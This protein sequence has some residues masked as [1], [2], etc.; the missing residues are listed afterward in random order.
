M[1]INQREPLI[2]FPKEVKLDRRVRGS[3]KEKHR[4]QFKEWLLENE[5][6]Y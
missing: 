2:R 6:G 1:K 3:A 4:K 5:G